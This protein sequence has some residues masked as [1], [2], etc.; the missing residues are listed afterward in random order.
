[1][2]EK[3]VSGGQTGV[4]RAAL[5][6]AIELDSPYGGWCP[7]GR[8]DEKGMI[9]E[10]YCRLKEIQGNFTTE[11]ENYDTRTKQNIIDSDGTLILVP[12]IPLPPEIRDGTLLTIKEVKKQNEPYL[13]ID[14]S[15]APSNNA[16]LIDFWAKY[17]NITTLNIAGPRESTCPG[18]YNTSLD[19]LKETVPDLIKS[20]LFRY[21]L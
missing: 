10:K 14:L 15:Q 6:V 13:I 1:M 16:T 18:I 8:I 11:K 20:S 3:I 19:L 7:K 4:D 12:K 17:H 21:K 9:P 5:D 2:I